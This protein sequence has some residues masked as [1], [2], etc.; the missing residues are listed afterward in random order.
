MARRG[1]LDRT[2]LPWVLEQAA[3]DAPE[4]AAMYV[5]LL[6]WLFDPGDLSAQ[7]AAW[8]VRET[9]LWPAFAAWFD[10]ISL[11]SEEDGNAGTLRG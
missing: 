9:A 5:P 10:P 6:R 2:D 3:A 7:E 4:K 1:L 11:G 8:A